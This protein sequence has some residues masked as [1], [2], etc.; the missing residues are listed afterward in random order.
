MK[1]VKVTY[2]RGTDE[3][4]LNAIFEIGDLTNDT[5]IIEHARRAVINEFDLDISDFNDLKVQV[6]DVTHRVVVYSTIIN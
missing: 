2:R 1:I 6:E 3:D 5:D 4:N